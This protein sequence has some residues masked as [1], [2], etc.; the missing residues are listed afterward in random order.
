MIFFKYIKFLNDL[1]KNDEAS[2]KNTKKF[3]VKRVK[4]R[5]KIKPSIASRK[6]YEDNKELAR[7]I[8]K[9]RLEIINGFYGFEYKKVAI[10]DTKSRWG[11]CSA[12]RNLNFNYKIIF[13]PDHLRDYI[14]VHELC[15]LKEMNHSIM[16]WNEVAKYCSDYKNCRS[17]L[18]SI[19]L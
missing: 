3:F 14:I 15:H 8:I 10:R 12:R 7:K 16:F 5:Q 1:N 2:F 17:E 9:E 19:R 6:K 13:L 11:S 18:K 4:V